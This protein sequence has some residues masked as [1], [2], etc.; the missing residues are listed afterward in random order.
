LMVDGDQVQVVRRRETLD[1]Q[2]EPESCLP[3]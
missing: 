1:E 2:L 3:G